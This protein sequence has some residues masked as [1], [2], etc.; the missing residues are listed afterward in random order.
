MMISVLLAAALAAAPISV[1]QHGTLR[2]ALNAIAQQ[3]GLNL[4]ITGDLSQP[5][6][7][8]LKDVTPEEAIEAVAAAYQL[9]VH[10][11]GKVWVLKPRAKGAEAA[12]PPAPKA[13]D[14]SPP[15]AEES[16]EAIAA[17]A[18]AARERA[19]ELRDRAEE[20]RDRARDLAE[21]RRE[22]ARAA[23]DEARATLEQARATADEA[24]AGEEHLVATGKALVVKKGTR[25]ETAV[26]YGGPVTVEEG[27]EVEND[28]VS[29]GGDVTLQKGARVGGDAVS[30]GGQ[31]TREDGAVVKGEV[32]SMGS[33]ALGATVAKGAAM[34]AEESA[35][36][37]GP[38]GVAGFLLRFAVLFGLGF[39]F[40]MFAPQ[41]VRL[42]EQEIQRAPVV[43]G[44][45][46]ALGFIALIPATV[47]LAITLIGIPVA[48]LLW[49]LVGLVSLFGLTAL[50]NLIGARL[51]FFKGRR[52][53]ALVLAVGVFAL[54]LTALI[55]VV[56]P[57]ALT[58]AAC[59]S[60]GAVLRTRLGFKNQSLPVPDGVGAP[61]APG[62]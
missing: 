35:E 24:R 58:I 37:S 31:V 36:K 20:A 8:V 38:G 40:M 7:V 55:P 33:R 10:K 49:P 50:A 43:D 19:D 62:A 1:E 46:G 12:V 21:A 15:P 22:E 9:E 52:T 57:L 17:R 26:A 59:I 13:P 14:V 29:F 27:A 11:Q 32:V 54:L 23:A 44:A 30:F 39:V 3:G 28:V 53:Q 18:E 48:V 60:F 56:G 25:V 2:E 34:A 51:P 5:A 6:E 42:L 4:V 47:L 16:P 41:R 61:T 45:M